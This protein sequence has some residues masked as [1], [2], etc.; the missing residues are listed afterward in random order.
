MA[1]IS[2]HTN[3]YVGR[4]ASF[5]LDGYELTVQL[6]EVKHKADAAT[7]DATGFGQ[8]V[9][10]DLAGIQKASLEGKGFYAPGTVFDDVVK[11]RFGQDSD[12]IAAYGQLG[13]GVGNPIVMQPSVLTKYDIDI[14]AKG[15]VA[16]DMTMMARGYIDRGF[17]MVSPNVYTTT[18][19]VSPVIDNTLTTGATA[20]G[21]SAQIH[22]FD[23]SLSGATPS[24]TAVVQHSPDGTTWTPLITFTAA[25]LQNT[26]QRIVLPKQTVVQPQVRVSYTV[27]G[28]TPSFL[29]LVGW[30][31]GIV[32][33]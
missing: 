20:A 29:V 19:G 18:T 12:V 26:V 27:T 25:T 6:N 33:S 11:Q 14:K 8:R 2:S 1:A 31:R 28:T 22:V 3:A 15:D 23:T 16:V 7:I 13:W 32:Y 24:I 9:S 30:A 5:A 21:G 10:N 17:V 4:N